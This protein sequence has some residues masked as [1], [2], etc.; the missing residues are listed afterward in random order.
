MIE[1]IDYLITLSIPFKIKKL[2]LKGI[3]N[4]ISFFIDA[5]KYV[6]DNEI[7]LMNNRILNVVVA[8][9]LVH[10]LKFSR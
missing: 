6:F 8:R 5:N 4:V 1:R 3:D 10:V 7:L 9:R 2:I